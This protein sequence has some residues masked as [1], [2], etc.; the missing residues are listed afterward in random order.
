MRST[1]PRLT[2]TTRY[3][4][5]GVAA[6]CWLTVQ[7]CSPSRS[8]ASRVAPPVTDDADS[9]HAHHM[10]VVAGTA[11]HGG[12][13]L[14]V[15]CLLCAVLSAG[16]GRTCHGQ[17]IYTGG[18]RGLGP[19]L[20]QLLRDAVD[21]LRELV[22]AGPRRSSI[23]EPAVDGRGWACQIAVGINGRDQG[24]IRKHVLVIWVR[25][26][27]WQQ[28]RWVRQH[29]QR[30]QHGGGGAS[31]SRPHYI[32][33]QIWTLGITFVCPDRCREHR[34]WIA[35][36]HMWHAVCLGYPQDK[37]RASPFLNWQLRRPH[38]H[39]S[40][41]AVRALPAP[42]PKPLP[43]HVDRR[44]PVLAQSG[45]PGGG[46]QQRRRHVSDVSWQVAVLQVS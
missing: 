2:Q 45:G 40:E 20:P 14:P 33:W 12:C 27:Q 6:I 23:R 38:D 37:G 31:G 29:T 36:L 16:E 22:L 17:G 30:Q 3:W 28:L 13:W 46:K 32:H 26:E 24:A 44:R 7:P 10:V 41:A 9:A 8:Q 5:S 18:Q 11:L 19:W 34:P 35:S 39:D 1:A 4:L 25:Q 21:Y 15:T 43:A 42:G